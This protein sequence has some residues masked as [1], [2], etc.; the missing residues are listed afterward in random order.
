VETLHGFHLGVSRKSFRAI[1]SREAKFDL[2]ADFSF[3]HYTTYRPHP[4]LLRLNVSPPIQ[5]L[6]LFYHVIHKVLSMHMPER[7]L[8]FGANSVM[9]TP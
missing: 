2:E 5:L 7:R 9:A 4:L 1:P 8:L 3:S 6:A